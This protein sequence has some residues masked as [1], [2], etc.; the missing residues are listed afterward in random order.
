MATSPWPSIAIVP[1]S[2][3]CTP[4]RIFIKV[5]LPA[6]FSPIRAWTSPALRSKST[7]FNA[8]TPAN[9]LVMLRSSSRGFDE[10]SPPWSCMFCEEFVMVTL[11]RGAGRIR[12]IL[13]V[14]GGDKR[15]R[16]DDPKR[17]GFAAQEGQR[18][19]HSQHALLIR[20]HR[21]R[22][23]HFAGSDGSLGFT[24]SVGANHRGLLLFTSIF[25]S[26]EDA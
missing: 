9:A 11:L 22:S 17:E 5:D 4:K 3:G 8:C 12:E 1:E 13:N 19:L 14:I 10:E 16:R 21:N 7:P 26:F 18:R 2:G 6:P 25:G 15:L 20:K 24:D 23:A